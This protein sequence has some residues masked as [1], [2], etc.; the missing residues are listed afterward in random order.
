MKHIISITFL[1]FLFLSLQGQIVEGKDGLFYDQNNDLYT[2]VY[3]KNFKNNK[4]EIEMTLKKGQKHGYTNIYFQAGT[5]KE[6]RS[7]KNSLMHG[8]WETW[9]EKSVKIAEANYKNGKKHGKWFVWDLNGILRY[10]MT[11][12]KGKKTGTWF[13]YNEKGDLVSSKVYN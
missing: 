8:K 6:K 13:I 10:D 4:V 5:L 7:Y 3:V 2:G 1:F 12:K 11:Y 9:N